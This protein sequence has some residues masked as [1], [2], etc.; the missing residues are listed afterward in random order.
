MR[1]RLLFLLLAFIVIFPVTAQEAAEPDYAI[2]NI[3]SRFADEGRQTVVVFEIWNI[4]GT[5]TIPATTTLRVIAT[6]E[7]VARD[8]VQ[9][10]RSQEI[11]TVSLTFPTATF[12]SD[13]VQSLRVAIGVDEI[14]ASGSSTIQNNFAQISVT[15][16]PEI[17]GAP[18]ATPEVPSGESVARNDLERAL[19]DFLRQYG[20]RLDLTNPIQQVV[21]VFLCIALLILVLIIFLVLR[22]L[23][24]RRPD[25]GNW[26]PSY[27]NFMPLDPNSIGGRRQQWQ[28]YAQNNVVPPYCT[29]MYHVRKLAISQE[30]TYMAGWR[31]D[32]IRI[33]QYDRFGRVTRSQILGRNRAANRLDAALRKRESLDAARLSKRLRPVAKMLVNDFQKKW[34]ERN[35][36]LPISL[37]VRLRGKYGSGRILFELYQCQGSLWQIIDS[38]EPEIAMTGKPIYE[39][40]TYTV[41]GQRPGETTRSFKARLQDDVV[42]VLAELIAL[43]PPRPVAAPPTPTNPHLSAVDPDA[44]G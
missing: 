15:I 6:G 2:R 34:S 28:G 25:F 43:E 19:A 3:R 38:W 24:R 8:I 33:G 14:E 16:P 11:V 22:M 7:E 44:V 30:G 40:Y 10:L 21:M 4:G 20:I 17:S 29:D 12:P 36:M 18:V 31:V 39:C 42:A 1:K 37:D 41:H 35:V 26:Q 5:A 13:S 32:A 27:I 23:F 9:P